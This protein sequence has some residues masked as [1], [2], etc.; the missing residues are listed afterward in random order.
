MRIQHH[1]IP[2]R[3]AI[4]DAPSHRCRNDFRLRILHR[5]GRCRGKLGGQ[6]PNG[7]L[8]NVQ[9][10]VAIEAGVPQAAQ[11]LFSPAHREQHVA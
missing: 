2:N 3:H 8:V 4:R 5:E 9:P 1:R 7:K 11:Q 6:N 10:V